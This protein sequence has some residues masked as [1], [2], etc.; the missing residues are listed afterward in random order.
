MPRVALKKVSK[1][2]DIFPNTIA[3]NSD[4][5]PPSSKV[6]RYSINEF[7][8]VD[9]L[10][11]GGCDAEQRFASSCVWST[12]F[13]YRALELRVTHAE[14]GCCVLHRLCDCRPPCLRISPQFGLDEHEPTISGDEQIIQRTV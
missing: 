11:S 6:A 3:K 4:D 12:C 9:T 13:Q 10:R 8:L 5:R 7:S 2:K 1:R 14:D